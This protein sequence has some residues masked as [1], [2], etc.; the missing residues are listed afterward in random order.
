M[1]THHSH[2]EAAKEIRR[3][4]AWLGLPTLAACVFLA[5]SLAGLGAWLL[6]PAIVAGPGVGGLALIWLALSSDTNGAHAPGE[7]H[8]GA[9]LAVAEPEA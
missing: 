3:W 9:Q 6:F 1:T 4:M 8:L 2:A 7:S 5:A